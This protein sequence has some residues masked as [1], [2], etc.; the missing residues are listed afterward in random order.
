MLITNFASGELSPA[1]NGRVDLR[2]Y[3][4]GAASIQNFEII[5][6]GGIKRRPGTKR[7]AQLDGESRIIPFIVDKNNVYILQFALNPVYNT[8]SQ[9]ENPV[10]EDIDLYYIKNPDGTYSKAEV[11]IMGLTYYVLVEHGDIPGILKIWKQD[12]PGNYSDI[13]TI[14]TSY[15]SLA[16]IKEIQ[17]AQN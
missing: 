2:Q 16:V 14:Y 8:Y 4:Q 11:Y 10:P 15:S 13:Q 5:P 1:L 12:L 6:T 3:Y 7:L 9:V 17:Y